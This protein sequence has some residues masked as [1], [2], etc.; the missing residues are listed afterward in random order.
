MQLS[1]LVLRAEEPA[2]L[3]KFYE[4]LGLA[5]RTEQHGHGPKHVAAELS[6]GVLEIYPLR[7]GEPPTT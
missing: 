5:F 3:A 2:R 7:N 6:L 1:H 4:A